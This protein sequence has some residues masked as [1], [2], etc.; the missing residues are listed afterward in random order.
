MKDEG[1]GKQEK[2]NKRLEARGEIK[3]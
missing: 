1:K 2:R 3:D